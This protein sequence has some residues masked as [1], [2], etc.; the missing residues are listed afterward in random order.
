MCKDIYATVNL[1]CS[2]GRKFSLDV[3]DF[4]NDWIYLQ[5]TSLIVVEDCMNDHQGVALHN[6]GW[7]GVV[8]G[9]E[10][11]LAL[12][13]WVSRNTY[14][15]VGRFL[16]VT[17]ALTPARALGFVFG[18]TFGVEIELSKMIFLFCI[19]LPTIKGRP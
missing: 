8:G 14:V 10:L 7:T 5:I 1:A 16:G 3:V 17:A 19:P 4:S 11:S 15:R 13:E 2:P 6:D 9:Q 18:R 12:M